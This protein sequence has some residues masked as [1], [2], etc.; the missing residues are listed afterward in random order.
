MGCRKWAY[1]V[2]ASDLPAAGQ[3]VQAALASTVSDSPA[4]KP[5]CSAKDRGR[6]D[7][8]RAGA[9]VVRAAASADDPA[10]PEVDLASEDQGAVAQASKD[11]EGRVAAEVLAAVEVLVVRVVLADEVL[12]AATVAQ[13][14][15]HESVDGVAAKVVVGVAVANVGGLGEAEQK[16]GEVVTCGGERASLIVDCAGE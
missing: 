2:L 1:S 4:D 5:A 16:V 6:M 10:A 12:G 11:P 15:L 3:V 13:V 7:R 8:A 9:L 14:V